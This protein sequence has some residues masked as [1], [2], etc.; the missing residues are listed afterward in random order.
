VAIGSNIARRGEVGYLVNREP[1]NVDVAPPVRIMEE[2]SPTELLA[3]AATLLDGGWRLALVAAH[4]DDVTIRIVYVFMK[5]PP[6]ERTELVVRLDARNPVLPSIASISFVASRFEREIKDLFGVQL[7]DHPQARRLVL[8][9]HWPQ[10]WFPMRHRAGPMP[11]MSDD[12]GSFPFIPVDGPGVYEIP[13]GPVHAGLIE[14]GHFRFFVVGETILRMKARLWFTHKGIERL[15]E[16]KSIEE[17]LQIAERVSGDT[18]VGHS[19]AYV[20]AIEEALSVFVSRGDRQLRATLVEMERLYNHVA[21]LGALCNDVG[22]SIA[23][24][25]ALEIR[26]RLLRLNNDVTGHRLLRDGVVLGGARV[27][28]LASDDELSDIEHDVEELVVMVRS[29]ALVLDR[30]N[31]TAVL[32][33]NDAVAMGTLGVV[34]RASGC[35]IDARVAHPFVA[36]P[37]DFATFSLQGGDVLARFDVRVLEIRASLLCLRAW[38]RVAA[39]DQVIVHSHSSD[40][41]V[42]ESDGLGTVRSGLGVVEGWRG[43][44]VHRVEVG[45]DGLLSRVKIVDPSFMNWP[46]LPICLAETIIPDFPLANKSFNLSYAGNDL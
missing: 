40:G 14:P 2:T 16:G 42:L 39:G 3:A 9:Q 38:S 6:D 22:F 43:T 41:P 29:N 20:M 36:M 12:S 26:E 30:F 31:G 44:I 15:M 11:P 5:G 18:A 8:H 27:R 21:D 25:F 33:H 34:A 46:A 4:D 24:A 32:S 1:L 35:S 19:L 7:I 23:N 10:G 13:V 45:S 28:R 37:I 17:G